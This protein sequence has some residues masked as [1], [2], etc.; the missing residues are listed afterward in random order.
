MEKFDILDLVLSFVAGILAMILIILIFINEPR[1][2]EGQ[3]D[4]L[5]GQ[6]KYELVIQPDSTRTWEL[7]KTD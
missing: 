5:T 3:I 2:K 7:I 4:A 1:Y 6:I